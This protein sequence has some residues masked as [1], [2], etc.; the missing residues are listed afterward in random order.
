[1]WQERNSKWHGQTKFIPTNCLL[2]DEQFLNDG[3]TD[4]SETNLSN[5][6]KWTLMLIYVH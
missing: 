5:N 1:M 4:E 2:L 6:N 3:A